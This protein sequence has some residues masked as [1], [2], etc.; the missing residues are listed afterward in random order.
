MITKR[1]L[2][3]N[4]LIVIAVSTIIAY[5]TFFITKQG[6]DNSILGA[7]TIYY[8]DFPF[9]FPTAAV[10]AVLTSL[11]VYLTLKSFL[12]GFSK[13][14]LRKGTSLIPKDL[15]A[16]CLTVITA[17]AAA[18]IDQTLLNL[19]QNGVI[20]I[21][22][23]R[24]FNIFIPTVI[25]TTITISWIALTIMMNFLIS[26]SPEDRLVQIEAFKRLSAY[27]IIMKKE[28]APTNKE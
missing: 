11:C 12:D 20:Y 2:L 28:E 21:N 6:I 16:L 1:K 9:I 26:I 8:K 5:T 4:K 13:N 22:I 3:N 14:E 25:L 27:N 18:N 15:Q 19:S 10:T 24:D 7:L 17:Y 23:T